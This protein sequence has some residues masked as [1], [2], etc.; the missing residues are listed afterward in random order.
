M[1]T[2]TQLLSAH[3]VFKTLPFADLHLEEPRHGCQARAQMITDFLHANKYVTGRIWALPLETK[4]RFNAPIQD[5]EGNFLKF[6]PSEDKDALQGRITWAF[7]V[8]ATA[9][10]QKGDVVVF[11]PSLFDGPVPEK[12]WKDLFAGEAVKI[13]TLGQH[14]APLYGWARSC[15]SPEL[16]QEHYL[17]NR[18]IARLDLLGIRKQCED[19]SFDRPAYRLFRAPRINEEL[20]AR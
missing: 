14:E 8:A 9:V 4:Q 18:E 20:R 1:N 3:E 5:A 16:Q 17:D 15:Y 6:R 10:T 19:P 12:M 7:H 13:L 2:E 11:D